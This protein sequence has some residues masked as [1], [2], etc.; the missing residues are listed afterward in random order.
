MG[1][2]FPSPFHKASRKPFTQWE[3]RYETSIGRIA[4]RNIPFTRRPTV[5]DLGLPERL[6]E[7]RIK[8]GG[9]LSGE[10]R[11]RALAKFHPQEKLNRALLAQFY[12]LYKKTFPHAERQSLS[13]F[14]WE[15]NQ[16]LLPARHPEKR[17]NYHL[18]AAYDKA[19][20]KL[21]GFTAMASAIKAKPKVALLGYIV[22]APEYRRKGLGDLLCARKTRIARREGVKYLV[23]E[24][25]PYGAPEHA[26]FLRLTEKQKAAA[27]TEPEQKSLQD[28]T[29]KRTRIAAFSKRFRIAKDFA[30]VQ[31]PLARGEPVGESVPLSLYIHPLMGRLPERLP[32][33]EIYK[34]V[35]GLSRGSYGL[36]EKKVKDYVALIKKKN[37][38]KKFFELISPATL[39]GSSP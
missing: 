6:L 33:S 24:V 1:T 14:E 10:E 27:L 16:N 13:E 5:Y 29:A 39:L 18:I 2:L 17:E 21:L 7:E 32:A 37:A 25:E 3:K 30:Y 34:L 23:G 11:R 4:L 12:G 22:V 19:S 9:F 35:E 28:L 38:G 20:K 31:P 36:P 8:Q 15:F 26:Q